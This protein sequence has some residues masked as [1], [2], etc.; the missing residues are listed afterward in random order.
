MSRWYPALSPSVEHP[1]Y[2]AVDAEPEA[3][4]VRCWICM[5]RDCELVPCP[6]S[7]EPCCP[8]CAAQAAVDIASEAA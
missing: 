8:A 4:P 2:Y 3:E 5:A 1:D 7:D 6:D